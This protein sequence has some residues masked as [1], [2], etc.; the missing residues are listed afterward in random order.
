MKNNKKHIPAIVIAIIVLALIV[1][2]V[3]KVLN[4]GNFDYH[5]LLHSEKIEID[6]VEYE[7]IPNVDKYLIFGVDNNVGELNENGILGQCDAVKLL[8]LNRNDNTYA[9]ID[10]SRETETDVQSLDPE[11]EPIASTNCQLE[12]AHIHG[13]DEEQACKCVCH[14]VS[15]LLYGTN[16]YKYMAMDMRCVSL[17]NDLADGVTVTVSDDF[18]KEDESLEEGKT[19]RLSDEQA[20]H[21]V[22]GRMSVGEGD[23][24]SRMNRQNE[25]MSG[26]EERLSEKYKK[27]SS[28]I[29]TF[30]DELEKI[31]YSNISRKE[32][33]KIAQFVSESENLGIFTIEGK[34]IVD[35]HGWALIKPY[36]KS[37]K[38]VATKL[39]IRENK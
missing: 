13:N 25:F 21:Y 29:D 20:E 6:G 15:S 26:V 7:E 31:T 30:F 33:A 23:N 3:I 17:L 8:V 11:G 9:V 27:D 38:S 4:N 39:L 28:F 12:F 32:F 22:Q 10:I 19:V 24:N 5:G 1:F 18:S 2:A 14:S 35:D 36:D 37:R 34:K 16:I